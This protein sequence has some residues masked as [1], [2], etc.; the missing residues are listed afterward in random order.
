MSVLIAG[1]CG[2][3][4]GNNAIMQFHKESDRESAYGVRDTWTEALNAPGASQMR[5]MKELMLSRSYF[6]RIPA[7]DLIAEKQGERYDFLAATKGKDY[8]FIYTCNGSN[9]KINLEKMHLSDIKASWFNPR[10]GKFTDIGAY[11]ARG[12]K[13]FDPPGEK[14][15]GN[16]WVLVLDRL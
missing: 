5:Y 9:M 6:D 13:T 11:K 16:D 15:N 3:T 4:Y 14:V 1:G 12:I 10:N 8:A 7:Q 2:F